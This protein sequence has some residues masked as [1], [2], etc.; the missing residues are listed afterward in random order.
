[1]DTFEELMD[2]FVCTKYGRLLGVDTDLKFS[3]KSDAE[4]MF[5]HLVWFLNFFVLVFLHLY[6]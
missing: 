1:M 6:S 3:S 4:D 2:D 5:N